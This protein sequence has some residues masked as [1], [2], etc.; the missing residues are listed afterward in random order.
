MNSPSHI[1]INLVLLGSG[2]GK[3]HTRSILAGSLLPD[4]PI[5]LFYFVEKFILH[6]REKVIWM[7]AYFQ[8]WWQD[9]FD[10]F[11]SIPIIFLGI[12]V[13]WSRKSKSAAYFLVSMLLHVLIDFFLHHDDAHRIF[14]PLADWRFFSP[15][16]YWDPSHYG[17]ITAPLEAV[18]AIICCTVIF[19][20]YKSKGVK[21]TISLMV[22]LYTSYLAMSLFVWK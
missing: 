20:R 16:S 2:V 10:L 9:F 21:I 7:E 14:F 5:F 3:L 22:L 12:A 11:N 1:V 19:S 15:V 8:P 4:L 13:A 17:K 18:A 6:T